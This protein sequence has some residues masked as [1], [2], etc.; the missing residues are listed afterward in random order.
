MKYTA[1]YEKHRLAGAKIVE[2]AGYQMPVE[3]TGV[4]DVFSKIDLF[5][6]FPDRVAAVFQKHN[7]FV[8]V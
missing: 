3:Y 7:D 1:F 4:N 8:Q 2:F 5:G 6:N